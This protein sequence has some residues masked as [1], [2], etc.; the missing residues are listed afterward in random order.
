MAK[1]KGKRGKIKG[2]HALKKERGGRGPTLQNL[3]FCRAIFDF[4]RSF[5]NYE[6]RLSS[7]NNSELKYNT[8]TN[9]KDSNEPA[10]I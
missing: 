7:K 2:L 10:L 4:S 6:A 1:T 9:L 5:R 8:K 3:S